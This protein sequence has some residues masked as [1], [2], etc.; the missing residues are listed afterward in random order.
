MTSSD[1]KAQ[2]S[3]APTMIL[4]TTAVPRMMESAH[5][6]RKKSGTLQDQEVNPNLPEYML[7]THQDVRVGMMTNSQ[8]VGISTT[9]DP[10]V[11]VVPSEDTGEILTIRSADTRVIGLNVLTDLNEETD[12]KGETDQNG[13]TDL[14]VLTDLCGKKEEVQIFQ[15]AVSEL[16]IHITRVLGVKG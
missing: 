2:D 7:K 16:L 13:E 8:L 10:V 9:G 1:M 3:N 12:Q 4:I 15:S 14:N 11:Q 5:V 6:V